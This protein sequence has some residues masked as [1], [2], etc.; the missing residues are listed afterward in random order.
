MRD[1]GFCLE[2]ICSVPTSLVN[3]LLPSFLF[4]HLSGQCKEKEAVSA[5]P[6]L[7]LNSFWNPRNIVCSQVE[8]RGLQEAN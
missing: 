3:I 8:E 5:Q 7:K 1:S 4:Q 6:L 2:N